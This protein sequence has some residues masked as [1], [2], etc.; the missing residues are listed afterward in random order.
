MARVRDIIEKIT[1]V[2]N[3]HSKSMPVDYEKVISDYK[4]KIL[5]L[6][7]DLD[8]AKKKS[9]SH[10][11]IIEGKDAFISDLQNNI[12]EQ[13]DELEQVKNLLDEEKNRNREL[14][15][16]NVLLEEK[17]EVLVGKCAKT[18]KGFV[19]FVNMLDTME[20]T[21]IEECIETVKLETK[22]SISELGFEFISTYS[23]EFDPEIHCVVGTK[24]TNNKLLSEHIAEVVR[25]GVW[26]NNNCLIPMD[27]V[28]Y[29]IE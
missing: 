9:D 8:A 5:S 4:G 15:D 12:V 7:S 19:Q 13:K 16:K 28:I 2:G 27:V 17:N 22:Q 24:T 3:G 6:C 14:K 26:Y 1:G 21:S 18:A 23:G 20:F 29:T 10:Q 11:H 25:P